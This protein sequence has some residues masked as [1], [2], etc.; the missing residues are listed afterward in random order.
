MQF[1]WQEGLWQELFD[2]HVDYIAGEIGRA[3]TA[4]RL[5][6]YL[7]CPISSRGGGYYQT[8]IEI[9]IHVASRLLQEWGTR[10]WILNPA[11]YQLESPEGL[12]LLKGHAHLLSLEKGLTAKIDVDTLR[13]D[14]PVKGGDYMR[15]WSRVLLEDGGHNLGGK[16]DAFY[17]VGPSDVREFFTNN[18]SLTLTDGVESY[19]A[20]KFSTNR[21]F[22]AHF[23]GDLTEEDFFRFYTL[24]AGAHFSLGSHDE[25]NLWRT[26]NVLRARELGIALQIPGYFDGKQIGL[27]SAEAALIPGYAVS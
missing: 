10:F 17:F 21:E 8:N 24:K 27:G 5:V 3:H 15:M 4:G 14:S 25:Y 22:R 13:K 9:A 23:E 18:R 19:F 20:R 2:K 1:R 12:S 26:F 16:F 7:S 11:L 6:V